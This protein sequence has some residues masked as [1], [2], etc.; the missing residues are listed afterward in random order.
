MPNWLQL[1]TDV[2]TWL[3]TFQ[4]EMI[5]YRN[6]HQA[7][8]GFPTDGFRS[9]GMLADTKTLL[10][11]EI[12]ATQMNPDTNVGKYWLLHQMKQYLKIIL[13][14][15]YTPEFKSYP[16][17]KKLGE[18]YVEKMRP[19]VP[20]DYVLLDYRSATDYDATKNEI[21]KLIHVR[22]R[23]EFGLN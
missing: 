16:W 1:E 19:E 9:D 15:V 14:H 4:T 3:E 23:Q 20:I 22:L 13:F 21:K 8:L 6:P 11:V 10:A 5:S 17:R 18:F 12:E 2:T 7:I